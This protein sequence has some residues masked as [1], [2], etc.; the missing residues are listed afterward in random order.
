MDPTGLIVLAVIVL[1][2]IVIAAKTML[3]VP[4]A[5]ASVIERLGRFAN[6][7]GQD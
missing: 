5:T 7:A 6:V 2:V 1:L 3:L 4:Q